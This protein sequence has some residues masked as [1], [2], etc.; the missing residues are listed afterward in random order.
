MKTVDAPVLAARERF[1]LIFNDLHVHKALQN[2]SAPRAPVDQNL[3]AATM[4]RQGGFD[5]DVRLRTNGLSVNKK[6]DRLPPKSGA[7]RRKRSPG[8][9]RQRTT[10]TSKVNEVDLQRPIR[11]RRRRG[12]VSHPY[13]KL[14][15]RLGHYDWPR[16]S[17]VLP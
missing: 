13:K 3:A 15:R 2:F 7:E 1:V 11:R 17:R 9:E 16:N 12:K 14:V 6:M 8:R 5:G 4:R 10:P